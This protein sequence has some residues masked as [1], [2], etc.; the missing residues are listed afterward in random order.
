MPISGKIATKLPRKVLK[1]SPWA[2]QFFARFFGCPIARLVSVG[3]SRF[4][5][6]LPDLQSGFASMRISPRP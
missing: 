6:P 3:I 2:R 1:S 4:D 5:L